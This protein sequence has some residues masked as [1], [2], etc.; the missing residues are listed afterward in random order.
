MFNNHVVVCFFALKLLVSGAYLL[1]VGSLWDLN[2]WFIIGVDEKRY[3]DFSAALWQAIQD[4]GLIHA[5]VNYHDYT[6]SQHFLYYFLIAPFFQLEFPL[7]SIVMAKAALFGLS[8]NYIFKIS[9]Y[10]HGDF[11]A[12]LS[13]VAFFLYFP[14]QLLSLTY[15]RDDLIF[16]FCV[17]IFYHGIVGEKNGSRVFV[18]FA[19]L[20]LLSLLRIHAALAAL[21]FLA[22]YN[23][24]SIRG[25]LGFRHF[26]VFLVFSGFFF[27]WRFGFTVRVLNQLP[28]Y[29]LIFKF[30]YEAVRLV[31]SPNPFS[32]S[33]DYQGLGLHLW[34]AI[35]LPV[36][37]LGAVLFILVIIEKRI[38]LVALS[39]LAF[40]VVYLA[41]YVALGHLGF[42]QQSIVAH[43]LFIFVSL[44]YFSRRRACLES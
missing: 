19:Y 20:V 11:V 33:Q 36:S 28:I 12:R 43:I 17:G 5:I 8:A 24:K 40:T 13:V 35:S 31:L 32:V 23:F 7:V 41:P 37:V 15:M 26:L 2:S 42:R 25:A 1:Y 38:G 16:F 6:K 22:V 9:E 39:M 3:F 27:F 21:V 44:S 14:L 29:D 30:P 4:K 10:L 18:L 34:Y